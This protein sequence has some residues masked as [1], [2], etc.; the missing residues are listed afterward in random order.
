MMLHEAIRLGAMLRPQCFGQYSH[1]D[2]QGVR[3]TCAISGALE[4]MGF[5]DLRIM[6]PSPLTVDE[7][8]VRQ[9]PWA[10]E[11][12]VDNPANGHARAADVRIM[13]AILNDEG[14]TRERIA[15]WLQPIEEAYLAQQAHDAYFA[16]VKARLDEAERPV[17]VAR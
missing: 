12:Q 8:F 6:F 15:D 9:W 2:A 16:A 14:W 13:I 3:Y 1:L 17:E 10:A 4:A 11:L 7:C 5:S